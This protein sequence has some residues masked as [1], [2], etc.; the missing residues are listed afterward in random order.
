[1]DVAQPID[2]R[3][4]EAIVPFREVFDAE[5]FEAGCVEGGVVVG[6]VLSVPYWVWHPE[7]HRF[8]QCLQDYGWIVPFA[9]PSWSEGSRYFESPQLIEETDTETCRKLL[10]VIV[11]QDRFVEGNVC[12]CIK[13]G[14]VSKI[15][16]RLR[17]LLNSQPYEEQSPE[18]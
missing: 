2:S 3:A 18:S 14:L 12:S 11:R 8:V 17:E 10:T 9:W 16:G 1:M 15:L 4:I 5:G 7:V 13:S 6:G